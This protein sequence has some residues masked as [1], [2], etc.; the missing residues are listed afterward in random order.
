MLTN[1]VTGLADTM[2]SEQTAEWE[3]RRNLLIKH[4]IVCEPCQPEIYNVTPFQKHHYRQRIPQR[5]SFRLEG[6]PP[7]APLCP[8]HTHPMPSRNLPFPE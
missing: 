8:N 5:R 7:Q 6:A 4:R 1:N 2:L 3:F